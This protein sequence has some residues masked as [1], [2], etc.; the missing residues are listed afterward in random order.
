MK[1]VLVT[2]AH[3]FI[4]KNLCASLAELSEITILKFTRQNTE[5]D[6]VGMVQ[7]ADF[8]FHVAGVNRPLDEAEFDTG[9]RVFTETIL[10]TIEKSKKNIPIL[11][12]S[13]THAELENPYGKSKK[14]AEDSVLTW[15]KKTGNQVFVYRL[16][17]VFGKWAKPDYNSVVATFCYNTATNLPL[18]ISNPDHELTLVYID[19][20]VESFI[21]AFLG[22]LPKSKSGFYDV[23]ETHT[24]A[25]GELAKKIQTFNKSRSTLIMPSLES[26]FDRYLYATFTSY[27][28]SNLFSYPLTV[29]TDERGWLAEFIKSKQF[30]Q[31]FVSKTKPGITRGNHWHHTKVEKFLVIEGKAVIKFRNLNSQEVL[32]YPVSGNKL[33]P[34][35]IPVG[36]VHSIENTGQS[37]LITLFWASEILN[38]ES[39]D[40]YYETV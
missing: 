13:S 7:E 4:G 24:V 19:R 17:N 33:E 36:Y 40:T 20:V 30:G 2:G 31:V 1:T 8:V 37:D 38:P 29:N 21:E 25:L 16:T 15:Q 11:I 6:L 27:L 23:K 35:D 18:N 5:E 22:K 39:P 12:T 14:A 26:N 10:S 28:P 9:N 34:V 32:S 3:G